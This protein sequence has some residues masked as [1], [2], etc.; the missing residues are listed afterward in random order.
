[1]VSHVLGA[2][3]TPANFQSVPVGVPGRATPQ[4]P[5]T[6]PPTALA[7]RRPPSLSRPRL[8]HELGSNLHSKPTLPGP[9]CHLYMLVSSPESSA[10]FAFPTFFLVLF[11][12]HFPS[13]YTQAHWHEH[14]RVCVFRHL[15]S[16]SKNFSRCP[17]PEARAHI[18]ALD[19]PNYRGRITRESRPHL[20]QSPATVHYHR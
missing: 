12:P 15:F 18:S 1:M 11:P 13:T 7:H 14:L 16:T 9:I 4:G 8:I 10:S 20:H 5:V 2:P 19:H 17:S 6:F 3:L